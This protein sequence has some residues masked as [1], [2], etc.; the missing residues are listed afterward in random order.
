[1]GEEGEESGLDRRA[2]DEGRSAVGGRRVPEAGVPLPA[3]AA[4]S[5]AKIRVVGATSETGSERS[6]SVVSPE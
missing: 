1:M 3:A 2:G 5:E 4:Q 6:M